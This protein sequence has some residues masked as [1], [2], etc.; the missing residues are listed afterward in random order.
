M[1]VYV[2]IFAHLRV[3]AHVV[4]VDAFAPLHVQS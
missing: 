3:H 1:Y 2:S 4:H